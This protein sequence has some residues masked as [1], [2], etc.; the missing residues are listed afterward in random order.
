MIARFVWIHLLVEYLS[1]HCRSLQRLTYKQE[2]GRELLRYISRLK[3]A[4]PAAG[5]GLVGIV[6]EAELQDHDNLK[7]SV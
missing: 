7:M 2:V 3:V 5:L 1:A 4:I 6:P